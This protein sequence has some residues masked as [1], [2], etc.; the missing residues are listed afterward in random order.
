MPDNDM[1]ERLIHTPIRT[2]DDVVSLVTALLERPVTRQCWVLFLDE[3]AVPISFV[4][5]VSELPWQPDEHVDDLAALVA[6][7]VQQV[8]AAEVVLVWERP[9]EDRLYPVDWEWVDASECALREH[10]VR[11]RA[12]VAVHTGGT[13][14]VSLDEPDGSD[15]GVLALAS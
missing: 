13:A 4:M 12:Q 10:D 6:D 9:G 7:V 11:L 2:D 8:A 1:L 15:D 5:P 3:R 14:I